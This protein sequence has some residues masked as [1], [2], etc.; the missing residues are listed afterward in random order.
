MILTLITVIML[1]V[2]MILTENKFPLPNKS[3]LDLQS[4]LFKDE[5]KRSIGTIQGSSTLELFIK[6]VQSLF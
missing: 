6:L 4:H 3:S 1:I 5:K 2:P